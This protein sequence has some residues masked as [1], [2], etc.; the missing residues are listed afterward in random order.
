MNMNNETEAEVLIRLRNSETMIQ[1]LLNNVS[2]LIQQNMEL[3]QQLGVVQ[4]LAT[5]NCPFLSQ[6][7]RQNAATCYQNKMI[8]QQEALPGDI[9][10]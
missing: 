10:R 3:K 5:A 8:A 1:E 6:E 9:I 2:M 4:D 7:E